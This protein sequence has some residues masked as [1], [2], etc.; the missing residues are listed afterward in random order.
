[1]NEINLLRMN[2]FLSLHS[3][4]KQGYHGESSDM[5]P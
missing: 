5:I 1:M 2:N 4:Y 3:R